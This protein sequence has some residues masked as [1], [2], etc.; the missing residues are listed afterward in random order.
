MGF[1]LFRTMNFTLLLKLLFRIYM[2]GDFQQ[3][4]N[5]WEWRWKKCVHIWGEYSGEIKWRRTGAEANKATSDSAWIKWMV[6]V[7]RVLKVWLSH[8]LLTLQLCCWGTSLTFVYTHT[9]FTRDH[10]WPP[11]FHHSTCT[12]YPTLKKV[13]DASILLF[14]LVPCSSFP[15]RK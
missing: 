14:L 2:C 4:F 8:T 9:F 6:Y 15:E 5:K 3:A 10:M 12:P 13:S 7:H 11:R 1:T